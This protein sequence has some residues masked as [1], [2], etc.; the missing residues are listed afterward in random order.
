MKLAIAIVINQTAKSPQRFISQSAEWIGRCDQ[1]SSPHLMA[2]NLIQPQFKPPL[3]HFS[4]P[5]TICH[6]LPLGNRGYDV[7]HNDEDDVP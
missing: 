6:P 1:M 2:F 3:T 4:I 5:S 7:D